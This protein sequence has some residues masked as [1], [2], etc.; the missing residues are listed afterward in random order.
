MVLKKIL[1]AVLISTS[2]ISTTAMSMGSKRNQFEK[3]R[4]Q[5]TSAQTEIDPFRFVG[6]NWDCEFTSFKYNDAISKYEVLFKNHGDSISANPKNNCCLRFMQNFDLEL[7][8][9][10]NELDYL[11]AFNDKL[12]IEHN[13]DYSKSDLL[14]QMFCKNSESKCF[15]GNSTVNPELYTEGY[16]TCTEIK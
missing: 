12:I 1:L 4:K 10:K 14:Y 5:F 8:Q 11:R 6:Q 2:C 9:W 13:M 7:N 16:S 15:I 3:I